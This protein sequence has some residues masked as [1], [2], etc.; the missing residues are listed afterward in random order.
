MQSLPA[1]LCAAY[2]RKL[3]AEKYAQYSHPSTVAAFHSYFQFLESMYLPA[4]RCGVPTNDVVA[5][6]RELPYLKR[7]E[8]FEPNVHGPARCRWA[9]WNEMIGQGYESARDMREATEHPDADGHV[10]RDVVG[11]SRGAPFDFPYVYLDTVEG[12][13]YWYN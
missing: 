7:T 3:S 9:N 6:L 12:T 10:P 8:S 2:E 5:L 13:V 1:W 11:L 4:A